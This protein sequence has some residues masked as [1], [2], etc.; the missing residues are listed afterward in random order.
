MSLGHGGR[1]DHQ[2]RLRVAAVGRNQ[3]G[4]L[5]VVYV[6]PFFYQPGRQLAGRA[7]V[8]CDVFPPREEITDEGAHADAPGSDEID[9]LYAFDVHFI[10]V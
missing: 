3:V 10:L 1:V 7:V 6:G 8:A 9:R 4:V 5:L 2:R